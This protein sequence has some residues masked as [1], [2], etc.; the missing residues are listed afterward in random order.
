MKILAKDVNNSIRK[1]K[2]HKRVIHL[3]NTPNNNS[4]A[5]KNVKE[6]PF[7]QPIFEQVLIFR[8]KLLKKVFMREDNLF[9]G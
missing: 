1:I 3:R 5:L 8:E 2:H 9:R 6:F 4:I 7:Y